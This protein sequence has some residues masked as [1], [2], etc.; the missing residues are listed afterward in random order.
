MCVCVLVTKYVVK[1]HTYMVRRN[2]L[3]PSVPILRQLGIP[4]VA[5]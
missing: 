1:K 5:W 3:D 2:P 4:C